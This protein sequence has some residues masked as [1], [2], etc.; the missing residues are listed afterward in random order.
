MGKS[1]CAQ[2]LVARG[3][4]VVDTD[5]LARQVVRPGEPA[6]AEIRALFGPQALDARGELD[7]ERMAEKVFGDPAARKQIEAILH[8][9]IRERWRA[10]AAGWAGVGRRLAVVVIPLL[11]ETQAEAELDA[12]VCVA[13]SAATQRER[14]VARGWSLEQI[15]ARNDAQWPIEKKLGLATY[16]IWTEGGLDVHEAQLERILRQVG[17][18]GA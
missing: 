9:R 10:Q 6:L 16:V 12:T 1:A 4:A 15:K 11:F 5:E 2:L 8:P 3:I 7:R 14:L 18:G 17:A 13:C